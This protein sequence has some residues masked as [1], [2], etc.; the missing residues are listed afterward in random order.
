MPKRSRHSRRQRV[1]RGGA[2]GSV[3]WNA[4]SKQATAGTS[5]SA[6][7]DGRRAPASDLGWCSGAR[8]VSSCS[9]RRT[10]SSTHDRSRK[11]GPPC[12]TRCPTAS[13]VGQR[14]RSASRQRV[15]VDLAA[16]RIEVA[17]AEQLVVAVEHAAASRLL[18]PALTTSD[19]HA[20]RRSA[21][22]GPVA[23]LRQVLAVRRACRR[24]ARSR[25]STICWRSARRARP[26]PRHAVD[27]VHH[28]VEAVE[29]VEHHHVERRR[30]GALLLVAAHVEVVVVGA[31]VGEPV[32]QPR[33]AVVGE[34]H[35]P[36]GGEQ[37]V[38]LAR[39]TAR[40]GARCRAAAASGR[41]R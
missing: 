26:E 37:R 7:A 5:G 15:A 35:R 14:R 38:E 18:E 3:A 31:P 23:D 25:A 39:R 4:V 8:S 21:R 40:A 2:P 27:H 19:A 12:T 41:R 9:A 33:V 28:E 16:R 24:G 6:R 29:V 30:G 13:G 1:R 17:L 20:A 32:D 22:P 34:D 36:V 10:S 11:R